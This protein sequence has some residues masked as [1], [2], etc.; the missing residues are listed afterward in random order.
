MTFPRFV[1]FGFLL[2]L[3]ACKSTSAPEDHSNDY[4]TTITQANNTVRVATYVGNTLYIAG[5]FDSIGGK[6]ISSIAKWDGTKW[7]NLASNLPIWDTHDFNALTSDGINLYAGGDILGSI[8]GEDITHIARFDG[9][10]LHHVPSFADNLF[11]WP[12]CLA[13]DGGVLYEF[14]GPYNFGR[15]NGTAWQD[16]GN[17][18]PG[19]DSMTSLVASNGNLYSVL[20]INTYYPNPGTRL[21]KYSGNSWS[22]QGGTIAVNGEPDLRLA[23]HGNDVYLAGDFAKIGTTS[24]ASYGIAKWNGSQWSSVGTLTGTTKATA[25]TISA[26]GIIYLAQPDKLLRF[27][28]NGWSV[29]ATTAGGFGNQGIIRTIAVSQSGQIA[30]GGEFTLVN[31]AEAKYIAILK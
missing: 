20:R 6:W 12:K 31:N 10:K 11:H 1:L 23:A 15:Y 18:S 7:S 9:E 19:I 28:G 16:L 22:T 27:D 8:N 21:W 17:P 3:A 26:D 24:I 13:Y 30:I 14:D 5:D 4:T 29:V 2:S 25:I